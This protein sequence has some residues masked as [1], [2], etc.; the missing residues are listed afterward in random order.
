MASDLRLL[1]VDVLVMVDLELWNGFVVIK[2]V[3][4]KNVREP[5]RAVFLTWH[6]AVTSIGDNITAYLV[7]IPL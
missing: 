1:I 7:L 4:E 3:D 6:V 2:M 5:P